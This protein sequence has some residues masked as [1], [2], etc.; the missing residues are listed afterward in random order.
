V[1]RILAWAGA[2]AALAIVGVVAV[3]LLLPLPASPPGPEPGRSLFHAHC[4]TCHGADG[5]G[6]S[7]RARL[8]L[9]RPGDLTA[10]GMAALP[11]QYLADVIRHGGTNFGKPGMPSFGFALG[12]AEIEALVAYLRALPGS[13]GQR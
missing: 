12:D 7:W 9:L 2:L 8:L 10:P 6:R 5:R 1:R 3:V 11:D 4:A 13:A